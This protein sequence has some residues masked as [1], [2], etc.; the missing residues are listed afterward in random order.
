MLQLFYSL[1][2][3]SWIVSCTAG[4]HLIIFGMEGQ[5]LYDAAYSI[6]VGADIDSV[7]RELLRSSIGAGMALCV[8]KRVGITETKV[9]EL[10]V[11]AY[12]SEQNIVGFQI[13]V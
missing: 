11:R 2:A 9:D 12:M 7:A 8:S 10:D 5:R 1:I 3:V 6:D 4:N 13:E